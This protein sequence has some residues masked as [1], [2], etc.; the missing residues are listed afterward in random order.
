V[1]REK[2]GDA[3]LEVID[4]GV[5]IEPDALPRVFDRFSS[6]RHANGNGTGTGLGLPIVK[7]IIEAHGGSVRLRSVPGVGTTVRLC[8]PGLTAGETARGAPAGATA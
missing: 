3:I 7:A 5:G 4:S 6:V 2:D 1:G 8:V